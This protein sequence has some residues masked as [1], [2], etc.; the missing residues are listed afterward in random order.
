MEGLS[1]KG[2][3]WVEKERVDV[4]KV[5][6]GKGVCWEGEGFVWRK[7]GEWLVV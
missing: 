5:L 4:L 3:G 7:K 6:V 1:G 2:V